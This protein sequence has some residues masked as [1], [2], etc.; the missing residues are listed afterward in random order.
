MRTLL[1]LAG[2]CLALIT[3]GAKEAQADMLRNCKAPIVVSNQL[4]TE[5]TIGPSQHR[6]IGSF[7]VP[8]LPLTFAFNDSVT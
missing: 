4:A 3:T 8:V 5:R 1:L 7:E 6:I 2:I